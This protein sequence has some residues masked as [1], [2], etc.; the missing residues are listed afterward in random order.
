MKQ[1]F[2]E[3]FVV[4]KSIGTLLSADIYDEIEADIIVEILIYKGHDF[5][6]KVNLIDFVTYKYRY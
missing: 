3:T 6:H 4:A 5:A 2:R 1:S